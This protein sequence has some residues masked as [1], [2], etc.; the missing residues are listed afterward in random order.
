MLNNG[1][2]NSPKNYEF[3]NHKEELGFVYGKGCIT[4]L[5]EARDIL[6]ESIYSGHEVDVIYTD[7]A[8]AFDKVPHRRLLHKLKAQ[9]ISGNI[10][11]WI[12]SWLVDRKQRVVIDGYMAEWKN[13]SSGVPQGS[14]LGPLLSFIFINDLPD[15]IRANI[16][17]YANDSKII[18]VITSE[19]DKISLQMEIDFED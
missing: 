8:K 9:G 19:E 5:L 15:N 11:N 6:T 14:V 12:E 1:E 13:V 10:Y 4:N 16:N 3:F 18:G 2:S 7:F 17:L